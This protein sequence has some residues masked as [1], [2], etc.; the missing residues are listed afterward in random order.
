MTK[1]RLLQINT[2]INSGST[3]RIAEEIGLKAMA[4][5]WESHIAYGRNDRPSKSHK[6]KI[7]G[8]LGIYW[9]VLIT[10]LFDRHGLGS[11]RATKQ[12]IEKIKKI[13]PDIIHLH[14][15]HGYYLNIQ[16]LFEFLS[17]TNIP[18]VWTLHD[19]WTMTGHCA[20]F[21]YIGCERWKSQCESCPQKK[22]YPKSFRDRSFKNHKLKKE[23]FLSKSANMVLVPVSEWLSDILRDSFLGEISK[24]VIHN[25]I[26]IDV[27]TPQKSKLREELRLENKF[28][29]LGVAS[30]WEKRKG[31]DD[32]KKLSTLLDKDEIIIL[33]GL[34]KKQVAELPENIIGITRTENVKQLA[35]FYSIA[36]VFVNPTWEDNYPTT[37][38]EATACG[39]PVV[40]Y[41]TGG[42]PESVSPKTGFVVEKGNIEELVSAIKII[43]QQGK[44]SYTKACR[45]RAVQKFNKDDRFAE[46]MEL[47]E[48]LLQKN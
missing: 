11:K 20:H 22:S 35:E 43:K 30:V 12:L 19:C 1:K 15:I 24:K 36:D 9:H 5:G 6:I 40:T 3:G 33:V 18:T 44:S 47:Y 25:G 2:V 17:T 14:N 26:D 39:T 31:L 27:F 7:G 4:N 29:L 41:K 38:L 28:I 23:L 45:E 13:E 34:S 48:E 32:F 10:R 42:S 37:N 8:K 46:Y 16:V 21:D